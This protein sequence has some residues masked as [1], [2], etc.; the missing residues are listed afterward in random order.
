MRDEWPDV[1]LENEYVSRLGSGLTFLLWVKSVSGMASLVLCSPDIYIIGE[2]TQCNKLGKLWIPQ[3]CSR[4]K[5][6]HTWSWHPFSAGK[7]WQG[8]LHHKAGL[9]HLCP[10]ILVSTEAPSVV[11]MES[12]GRNGYVGRGGCVPMWTSFPVCNLFSCLSYLL[13]RSHHRI[14]SRLWACSPQNT[15]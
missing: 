7:L 1:Y 10:Q 13:A 14:G 5:P 6:L 3:H 12:E 9:P 15:I 4:Q 11:Y 2:E 8:K